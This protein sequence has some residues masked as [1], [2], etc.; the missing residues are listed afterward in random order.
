MERGWTKRWRKRW[1]TGYHRDLLLWALIDYCVD[2]AN[3]EDKDWFDGAKK[4]A[5]KR[6]Q[7]VFSQPKLAEFFGVGRRKI[8][9]RLEVMKTIGFLTITTT[10]RYSIVTICNYEKY[11]SSET[12]SR[13]SKR[14]RPDQRMATTKKVKNS[15]NK[16]RSSSQSDEGGD[17]YLLSEYFKSWILK[18]NP[19]ARPKPKNW[20]IEI[21]RMIRIDKRTPEEI[22]QVIDFSQRDPFWRSNILSAGKLRKQF[23]QLSMKMQEN[24]R[25]S[26]TGCRRTD[27]NLQAAEA[28]IYNDNGDA[29][30]G[31]PKDAGQ[32][33]LPGG[34]D[35]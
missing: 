16:H 34:F 22:R 20:P 17:A 12:G 9:T 14:P 23:D 21:K 10:K 31:L 28:F 25:R 33:R 27:S 26:S 13:P 18:N 15:K 4:I 29:F 6:G 30:V 5:I 24:G 11:Q 8:R 7:L 19:K 2:Y 35:G 32:F 3:Y 1:D